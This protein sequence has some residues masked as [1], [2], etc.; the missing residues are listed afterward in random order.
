M[1]PVPKLR[2]K[3]IFMFLLHVEKIKN[4][5]IINYIQYWGEAHNNNIGNNF[6]TPVCPPQITWVLAIIL[7]VIILNVQACNMPSFNFLGQHWK[8][9]YISEWV[10][11][12]SKALLGW[13]VELLLFHFKLILYLKLFIRPIWITIET[14]I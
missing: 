3:L 9:Q 11:H 7:A 14:I 6:Q 13:C 10:T 5:Q 12:L 4:D 8:H 1:Q 2:R